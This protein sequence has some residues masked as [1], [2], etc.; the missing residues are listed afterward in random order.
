MITV[1]LFFSISL[2]NPYNNA[3]FIVINSLINL[4]DNYWVSLC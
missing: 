4:A 1:N 3:A 2:L